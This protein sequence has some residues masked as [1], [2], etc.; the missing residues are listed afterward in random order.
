MDLAG[1]SAAMLSSAIDLDHFLGETMEE[2]CQILEKSAKEAIGTYTFGWPQLAESTQ[3]Q[4]VSL[5]FSAN[6]PLLRTGALQASIGHTV[7]GRFVGWE[8]WVGTNDPKAAWQEFGTSR[9]IPPRP[10]LG[11]ALAAKG[12]E[13]TE[14]FAVTVRRAITRGGP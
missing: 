4:R 5:G 7:S 9:G 12:G 11:G 1:L 6:E 14:L 2:A 3:A 8:A 10:F 13:V